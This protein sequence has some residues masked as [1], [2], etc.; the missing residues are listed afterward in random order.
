MQ[1]TFPS[2]CTPASAAAVAA[3]L[4]L[5]FI[6]FM[7][8]HSSNEKSRTRH[9]GTKLKIFRF[10]RIIC[11]SSSPYDTYAAKCTAKG[12]AL[13]P[14]NTPR[15]L[16]KT[17]TTLLERRAVCCVA[18]STAAVLSNESATSLASRHNNCAKIAVGSFLGFGEHS[19]SNNLN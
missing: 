4:L 7:S 5:C 17:P 15:L 3:L 8:S 9:R 13:L 6:G 12:T 1:S 2:T 18:A 10:L 14:A 11:S 19:K 16:V